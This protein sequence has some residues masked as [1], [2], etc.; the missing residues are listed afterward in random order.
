MGVALTLLVKTVSQSFPWPSGSYNL[1]APPSQCSLRI[2][3]RDCAA[4][5]EQ[6]STTMYFDWFGVSVHYKEK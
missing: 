5:I 3:Y 4:D 1:P 2:W 6:D